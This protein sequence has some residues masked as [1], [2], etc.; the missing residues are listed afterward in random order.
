MGDFW[1]GVAVG[2]FVLI[3]CGVRVGDG[4]VAVGF[5]LC[6]LCVFYFASALFFSGS[7]LFFFFF[8]FEECKR[9]IN[10]LLVGPSLFPRMLALWT[11]VKRFF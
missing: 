5:L 1:R 9:S 6:V 4:F 3:G 8:F 7:V 11:D 10:M 2:R